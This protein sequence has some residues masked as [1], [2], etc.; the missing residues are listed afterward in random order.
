MVLSNTTDFTLDVDGGSKPLGTTS[1]MIIPG[2]SGTVTMTFNPYFIGEINATLTISS[3]DPDTP[4]VDVVLVGTS[5][6]FPEFAD[7]VPANF[8]SP[9][10]AE[11]GEAIGSEVSVGVQNNG[12]KSADAVDGN[13]TISFY[14]SSDLLWGETDVPLLNGSVELATPIAVEE[15]KAV[16]LPTDMAIPADTVEGNYYLLAVVDEAEEISEDNETNNVAA[17]PITIGLVGDDVVVTLTLKNLPGELT[18]NQDH[19]PDNSL[20]Y[21]WGVLVDTDNNI[22]T[23][24]G[25]GFDVE[26]SLSHFKPPEGSQYTSNILGGTQKNT[27]IL[28]G[29]GGTYGNRI[30]FDKVSI[31]YNETDDSWSIVMIAQKSWD[32]LANFDVNYRSFFKTYYYSPTGIVSDTTPEMQGNNTISDDEGD[33]SYSFIDIIEGKLQYPIP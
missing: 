32:E 16:T 17:N 28:S 22:T 9:S 12:G 27:W 18:F 26:I 31:V 29:S 4:S 11:P 13:I 25:S 6:T 14:L 15:T 5:M 1:P 21:R 19:V 2:G 30:E 7:L 24:D 10:S 8:T 23:G 33:V 3:N 20:E